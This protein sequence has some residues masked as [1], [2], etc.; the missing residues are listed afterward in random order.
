[1]KQVF[2]NT[3]H[4]LC[5][6]HLSQIA[7]TRLGQLK[8]DKEFKKIFYKC[9]SGCVTEEEFEQN[10]NTMVNK[11]NLHEHD[12]F[13]RLYSIREKWCTAL[14]KDFFSA[15]ILSSQRS[16]STNHAVGFKAN[17]TTTLTEFFQYS[18]QQ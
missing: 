15:G 10:W 18:R 8:A 16:E 5:L 12:L 7:N 14:S 1:M 6:W 3:R 17:K 4:R 2:P 9:L 11:Y 13:K